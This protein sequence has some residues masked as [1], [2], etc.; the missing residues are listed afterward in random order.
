MLPEEN[1]VRKN[2][3][4]KAGKTVIMKTNDHF[5]NTIQMR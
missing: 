2:L 1:T 3:V 4:E 5:Q